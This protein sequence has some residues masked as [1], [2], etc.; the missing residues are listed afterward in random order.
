MLGASV[1]LRSALRS[2]RL[3]DHMAAVD[4][5]PNKLQALRKMR[6]SNPEFNVIADMILGVVKGNG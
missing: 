4:S 5:H 2:K 6:E 1:G 3:R